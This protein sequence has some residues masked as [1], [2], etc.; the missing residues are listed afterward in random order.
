MQLRGT[1]PQL[2]SG[3]GRRKLPNPGRNIPKDTTTPRP[4]RR[5]QLT[6]QAPKT[7]NPFQGM[8][9]LIQKALRGK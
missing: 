3:M 9:G 8:S 7:T 6:Q 2:N 5:Q 4:R 1:F